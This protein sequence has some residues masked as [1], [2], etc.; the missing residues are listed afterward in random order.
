MN[1]RWRKLWLKIHRWVGLT[2]GLLLVLLGLTGSLLVFDHAIDEWLHPEVLL[3]EGSGEPAPLTEV[4]AAAEGALPGDATHHA[5]AIVSPRVANGVWTAWIQTG[6]EAAPQWTLVH[7]D[8]YTAQF[9]GSRVWGE[10]LMSWIYKLHYTLHGG[11]AGMTIVGIAGIVL[12]LSVATGIYL[13]WPLW[14]NSW[15]AAFAVRRDA[16]LHYDLHKTFGIVSGLILLVVSFTGVYMEFPEYVKP[17]V[18]VFSDETQPP[19]DLVSSGSDAARLT[20]EQAIAIGLK[21]FPDA[22]FDHFHPPEGPDG[23][24]EVGLRQPGEVNRSFGRTQLFIDPHGG[25]VLAV[26]NP[27]DFTAAD[28]FVA[29][30]FPLHN[31]EAF[32]LVGRWIVFAVGFAPAILYVTG[33]SMWW[34]RRQSRARQQQRQQ[35]QLEVVNKPP[36][37]PAPPVPEEEPAPVA[38]AD[39]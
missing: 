15:R 16:R 22:E 6:S 39:S 13:W 29:W 7:V 9:T 28:T 12:M 14:S 30:Q 24:Y 10:D 32:G 4:V 3:T 18:T 26:R 35:R 8:P 1:G 33:L 2:V 31:G 25:E 19:A 23:V 20:P 37:R 17:L 36:A 21:H 27:D 38:T 5:H 34:R 11:D